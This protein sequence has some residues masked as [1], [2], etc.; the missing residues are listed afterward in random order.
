MLFHARKDIKDDDEGIL[1][2]F[3]LPPIAYL[4]C[5]RSILQHNYFVRTHS[6]RDLMR[7]LILFRWEVLVATKMR[8]RDVGEKL[9]YEWRSSKLEA[10]RNAAGNAR[11]R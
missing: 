8:S 1:E 11:R 2:R 4:Y 7:M 10:R 5:V 6:Q 9:V 3:W